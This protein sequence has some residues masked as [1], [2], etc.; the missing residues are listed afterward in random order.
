[1][2]VF[3]VCPCNL[4]SSNYHSPS[5]IPGPAHYV[6]DVLC[7]QNTHCNGHQ[8]GVGH[9]E[10]VQVAHIFFLILALSSASLISD[11]SIRQVS[12]YVQWVGQSFYSGYPV[13]K[14]QA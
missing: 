1:M 2:Y 8:R 6:Y 9:A 3:A 12:I 13:D 4:G 11:P 14:D 5:S 7:E 10:A